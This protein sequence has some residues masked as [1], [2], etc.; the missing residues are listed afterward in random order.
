MAPQTDISLIVPIFNEVE[1]IAILQAEIEA[2]MATM[3]VDWEVIYVD[4]CS[5]DG[6][7]EALKALRG[8][9]S[10]VRI[11]K[12]RRNYG[13]TAAMAAGFDASEGAIVITLDG[14]LQNDPGDIPMMVAELERGGFDLVAGWRKDRQ[15]GFI[16]RRLPSLI[17]N[18]L[19][20]YVGGVTIHDTGCT[21]KAFRRELVK[22][23][24]IYAEQHRFLPVMSAGS[25]ARVCEVVVNHRPRRFGSSKYG[26]GRATRVLLDLLTIKLISQF[27]QRPLQYFGMLSLGILAVTI[28]FAFFGL[29]RVG[30]GGSWP[31]EVLSIDDWELVIVS[32]VLLMSTLVMYFGLLGLLAELTVKASGMHRRG[33]LDRILNELH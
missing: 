1:S 5:T 3:E 15:D 13:Q 19:I 30:S 4:D 31:G 17:A 14:D 8:T 2:A 26:I 21:L 32:V 27:S 7:L 9:G 20:G 33:I 12:F 6:S 24:P 23:M 16:L 28:L 11:L 29:V 10:R 25:G 22:N 18:R